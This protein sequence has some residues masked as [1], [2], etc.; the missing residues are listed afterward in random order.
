MIL[1]VSIR[2]Y[3]R[4]EV[5][6]LFAVEATTVW[7]WTQE[8]KLPVAG[9]TL[10]GHNRYDADVIDRILDGSRQDADPPA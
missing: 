2:T 3:K 6:R 1:M 10:G 8:G 9:K 5:A 4:S 7:R